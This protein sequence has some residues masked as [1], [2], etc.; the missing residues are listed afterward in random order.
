MK[1]VVF[2]IAIVAASFAANAQSGKNEIG[3]GVEIG[4][5]MGDFKDAGF[6]TG[7]GGSVKGLFG[8]GTAGQITGTVG[9]TSF[10]LDGSTDDAKMSATILP[11]MVGYRHNLSGFYLEPQIGYGIYGAKVT[12]DG[13]SESDSEG[14]FTYAAGVGFA[15]SGFDIGARYQAGSKDG[16]TTSIIGFRIGY[17]FSLGGSSSK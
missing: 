5:P 12:I 13:D 6:N 9:Y 1:K 14:A 17:N 16:S 7:F 11:I 8:I 3:V 2:A 15:K 10:K 4:L